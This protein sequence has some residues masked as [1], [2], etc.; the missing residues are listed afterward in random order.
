MSPYATK[1]NL[2]DR[3]GLAELVQRTDRTNIPQ[4][5]VDDTVVD[6]ALNDAEA[7]INTY[8]MT[9]Y[10]LPLAEVPASLVKP[11]CDI[12]RF[13]LHGEAADDIVRKAFEDA[14]SWLKDV[15]RGTASLGVTLTGTV[16]ATPSGGPQ[17]VA[18][19]RVF[20]QS[21]LKDF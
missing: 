15:S 18:P 21:T 9:N 19:G 16:A 20:D 7:K 8:L 14:V 1:Q 5:T 4:T 13:Y 11:A 17:F 12:A 3:F 2:I 10:T 6:D